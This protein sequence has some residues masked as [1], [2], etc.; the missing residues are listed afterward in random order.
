MA[1]PGDKV[2]IEILKNTTVDVTPTTTYERSKHPHAS[3]RA[4]RDISPDDAPVPLN[5]TFDDSLK[6]K[7][8]SHPT[9]LEESDDTP[10]PAD[11]Y[12]Q[13]TSKSLYSK[14]VHPFDIERLEE[15]S[16]IRAPVPVGF[17]FDDPSNSTSIKSKLYEASATPPKSK[18][19]LLTDIP[20]QSQPSCH[21][22]TKAQ[23]LSKS[24]ELESPL[25]V[26]DNRPSDS[27]SNDGL[28]TAPMPSSSYLSRDHHD[29]Y[30]SDAQS[31]V[32]EQRQRSHSSSSNSSGS[33]RDIEEG[34][35]YEIVAD[36]VAVEEPDI[37]D[38]EPITHS[39]VINQ[40]YPHSEEEP[41]R[42]GQGPWESKYC[43]PVMI[44]VAILIGALMIILGIVLGLKKSSRNTVV[45]PITNLTESTS[46]GISS[47]SI[48]D[49][50]QVS[51]VFYNQTSNHYII[52]YSNGTAQESAAVYLY[53]DDDD[54]LLASLFFNQTTQHFFVQY[55]NDTLEDVVSLS[56]LLV[57]EL[58]LFKSFLTT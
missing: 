50:S 55:K 1:P 11:I 45:T 53:I 13:S 31:R 7:V 43:F 16:S 38:A 26:D 41:T 27:G 2:T 8:G 39:I 57:R 17:V 23:E 56:S 6:K 46:L 22:D 52:E 54:S 48:D 33:S 49:H 44:L 14:Q 36:A 19:P 18:A 15:C 20:S 32:V 3:R 4:A 25:L 5:T 37:Y 35:H 29:Q 24:H 58:I 10:L 30:S 9:T 47:F 40:V 21:D 12:D 34:Q 28:A 51:N 42:K